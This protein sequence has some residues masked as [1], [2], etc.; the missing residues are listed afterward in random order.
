MP[1]LLPSSGLKQSLIPEMSSNR[2]HIMDL[3][4]VES[5]ALSQQCVG[6][7]TATNGRKQSSLPS[8]C[9]N[10]YRIYMHIYIHIY[11]DIYKYKFYEAD[12]YIYIQ[13]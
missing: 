4:L 13:L 1:I 9:S 8:M 2:Y 6:I 12:I 11:K 10:V 3:L 7:H 5:R